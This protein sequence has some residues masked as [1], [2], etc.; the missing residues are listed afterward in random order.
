MTQSS[1]R[2]I[3]QFTERNRG[4]RAVVLAAICQVVQSGAV[5][6]HALRNPGVK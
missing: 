1:V 5:I 2:W 6:I 3:L 4:I